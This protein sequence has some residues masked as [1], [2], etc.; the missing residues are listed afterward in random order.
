MKP[1]SNPGRTKTTIKLPNSTQTQNTIP[2]A[3]DMRTT[4]PTQTQKIE[5]HESKVEKR[6]EE[7]RGRRRKISKTKNNA[8]GSDHSL[9]TKR[10]Q[11]SPRVGNLEPSLDSPLRLFL[12]S[13]R[14]PKRI[15]HLMV[16]SFGQ[17]CFQRR[18]G[19]FPGSKSSVTPLASWSAS[20]LH[21]RGAHST[22]VLI[23]LPFMKDAD[24]MRTMGVILKGSP[25]AETSNSF[26][27]V[28]SAARS[29]PVPGDVPGC[30]PVTNLLSM[31]SS[32]GTVRPTGQLLKD[33][34][35]NLLLHK[36]DTVD[37]TNL[38]LSE[39]RGAPVTKDKTSPLGLSWNR[40]RFL[41]EGER[42]ASARRQETRRPRDRRARRAR[43]R[44][45][46]TGRSWNRCY[47]PKGTQTR[48][49][50]KR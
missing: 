46:E 21:S 32:N 12:T 6:D 48:A 28:E 16:S 34:R 24:S 15:L 37:T 31:F 22:T 35:R 27:A 50:R 43:R 2:C 18:K 25:S 17:A 3:T 41:L 45:Q 47:L 4:G 39:P 29:T 14:Q 10:C 19:A 40:G 44:L 33:T 23:P 1:P 38:T 11:R 36:W 49:W 20:L 8:H 9:F 13:I 7:S 42:R 26:S 5:E 30:V